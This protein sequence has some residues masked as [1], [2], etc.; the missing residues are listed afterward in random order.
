MFSQRRANF[1]IYVFARFLRTIPILIAMLLIDR[2]WPRFGAGPFFR[3]VTSGQL[4]ANCDRS[5]WKLFLFIS[6]Q[7]RVVDIVSY[8]LSFD[9]KLLKKNS[10]FKSV[11][12]L[13][14]ELKNS[15][16]VT[17][18]IL[19]ESVNFLVGLSP[20]IFSCMLPI[21]SPYSIWFRSRNS[22]YFWLSV[23][24]SA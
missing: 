1:F 3:Q 6:N 14:F 17:N 24:C 11:F 23:R 5:F 22:V 4:W 10:V 9:S 19:F 2:V 20:S 15:C 7:D 18:L 16:K 12:Y 13:N 21:F 8:P